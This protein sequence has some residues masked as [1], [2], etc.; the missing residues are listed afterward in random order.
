MGGGSTAGGAG[1][2]VCIGI[3]SST[4]AP[5][6][7]MPGWGGI[8]KKLH[9][10]STFLYIILE[11]LGHGNSLYIRYCNWRGLNRNWGWEEGWRPHEVWHACSRINI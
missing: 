2:F 9:S 3:G 1:A 5:T 6:T 4:G 11:A 7:A 8:G 10:I